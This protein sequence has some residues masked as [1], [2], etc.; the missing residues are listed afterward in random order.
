MMPRDRRNTKSKGQCSFPQSWRG[1][2][3]QNGVGEIEVSNVNITNHGHC[4]SHDGNN[5]YL[6]LNRVKL[7]YQCLVLTSKHHNLLQYKQSYCVNT[8][9]IQEVC[10]MITGDFPLYT[11]IKVSG[12]PIPCPFQGHFEFYYT[13][14]SENLCSNPVSS[15][16]ACA[17][18][19]R[20]NFHY[21]KCPLISNTN[22]KVQS[23]QCLA[24]WDSG[25]DS[26]LYGRFTG[27]QLTTRESQYRCFMYSV[28]SS[29]GTMSMTAD[30]TCQGL[31]S[32]SL[33]NNVFKL[34]HK[35]DKWPQARCV[36]P[37]IFGSVSEWRDVNSRQKFMVNKRADGFKVTE[38]LD[39]DFVIKDKDVRA[40][41]KLKVTCIGE[42][43]SASAG[44]TKVKE[45]LTYVTDD[46][47]ES[48]YRCVRFTLR[49]NKVVELQISHPTDQVEYSCRSSLFQGVKKHVLL[50]LDA[51]P[52]ACPMKGIYNYAHRRNGCTGRLEIGCS[53]DS[54]I[55]VDTK[56]AGGEKADILQCYANWTEASDRFYVIAGLVDDLRKAADCLVYRVT[57]NG[58]ELEADT[59]CG[60]DRVHL[61]GHPVEFLIKSPIKSCSAS[62]TR[63]VPV[64]PAQSQES[65]G[66][67]GTIG[68]S[69]SDNGPSSSVFDPHPG[70]GKKPTRI[71]NAHSGNAATR[72]ACAG[73]VLYVGAFLS[74][75]AHAIQR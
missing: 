16:N 64:I 49:T 74:F 28:Y 7:C 39:P 40:E 48:S 63:Q 31:Q 73:V 3:F 41:T 68:M 54:E 71:I 12:S 10:D 51:P 60:S 69:G 65:H 32:P 23:F 13:N 59:D 56:C 25:G 22:D 21:K 66:Q 55:V 72:A 44:Q 62:T 67:T 58:H 2:W 34:Y 27:P 11:M 19:S 42:V 33:G 75:L 53:R 15:I 26:Y 8:D 17:D 5:K 29:G 61:M 35:V 46:H 50:P 18:T 43:D 57:A 38:I 70:G 45:I 24:T 14:G 6:L 36:F 52:K 1:K 30:A 4:V 37:D 20:F 9:T 47:C